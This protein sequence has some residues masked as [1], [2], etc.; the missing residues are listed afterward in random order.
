MTSQM[1][2]GIFTQNLPPCICGI[3]DHTMNLASGFRQLG[4]KVV[5]LGGRGSSSCDTFIFGDAWGFESIPHISS[6]IKKMRLD[7]LIMQYT[8][9][10]YANT[11]R[12]LEPL[13]LFWQ[14]IREYC[15]TS[16]II[17]ETYFRTWRRPKTLLTGTIEKRTLQALCRAS[18]FIFTASEVLLYEMMEWNLSTIPVWLPISSNFPA[19]KTDVK[20]LRKKHGISDNSV[21][22][23]LFGGGT[24]LQWNLKFL[25]Y[26]E[27]YFLREK[28]AHNWLLL[29]GIPRAWLPPECIV[30]NPGYLSV[31]SLSEQ[32]SMTDIFLMPHWSGLSAKRG[33]LMAAMEHGLPVVGTRGYMTDMLWRNIDGVICVEQSDVI[34]FTS[35]V[36]N[37]ALDSERRRK[38]GI[39]NQKDFYSKFTWKHILEKFIRAI[40]DDVDSLK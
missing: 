30:I 20:I 29:G 6:Q 15:R 19:L 13:I 35:A 27:R 7:H 5:L 32:L 36:R 34:E 38:L 17:H 8:P 23:T 9:L 12:K 40:L 21:L 1:R 28:I 4:H 18:H 11:N 3:S 39:S 31:Q 33:T 10:M 14:E 16:L 24:N 22:L 2:I 25:W 37:L 26:L